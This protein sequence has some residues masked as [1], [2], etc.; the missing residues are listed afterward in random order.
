M[1]SPAATFPPS[2]LP[3]N[4][5][6][7]LITRLG[8]SRRH[9]RR[10]RLP[11]T[12]TKNDST[13]SSFLT[14]LAFTTFSHI[15]QHG[16]ENQTRHSPS[17]IHNNTLLLKTGPAD[18]SPTSTPGNNTMM[19][20]MTNQRT[21][22]NKPEDLRFT[23]L[24]KSDNKFKR[25]EKRM[26]DLFSHHPPTTTTKTTT[27]TTTNNLQLINA[28]KSDHNLESCPSFLQC[29]PQRVCPLSAS[30][31]PSVGCCGGG[32]SFRPVPSTI[33]H[34][35]F[36][37]R[38]KSSIP[39]SRSPEHRWT[40]RRGSAEEILGSSQSS[41]RRRQTG[42]DNNTVKFPTYF[43]SDTHRRLYPHLSSSAGGAA[44]GGGPSERTRG[45]A[46]DNPFLQSIPGIPL[47]SPLLKRPQ[48]QETLPL[49][50]QL[51]SFPFVPKGNFN[52]PLPLK[53]SFSIQLEPSHR[54]S[55]DPFRSITSSP[56]FLS[57]ATTDLTARNQRSAWGGRKD[58]A[59]RTLL[60]SRLSFPRPP[61]PS[62]FPT[63]VGRE[64][65]RRGRNV[66]GRLSFAEEKEECQSPLELLSPPIG[67]TTTG[68]SISSTPNPQR[69]TCQP[70]TTQDLDQLTP[71]ASGG[72]NPP[73]SPLPPN[74]APP[75]FEWHIARRLILDKL[76]PADQFE[77][78]GVKYSHWTLHHV[79]T[80]GATASGGCRCQVMAKV[81]VG[82]GNTG[83]FIKK[84]PAAVWHQQWAE[85]EAWK[86][87]YTTDGEN[88]VGEAAAHSFLSEYYPN[89]VPR[90]V[91]ILMEYSLP[92]G[93]EP[94]STTSSILE[95]A[96]GGDPRQTVQAEAAS[97]PPKSVDY[98]SSLPSPF[99][100][101]EMSPTIPPDWIEGNADDSRIYEAPP[102]K[103][104]TGRKI[105]RVEKYGREKNEANGPVGEETH[106]EKG[107]AA[108]TARE[109]IVVKWVNECQRDKNT[110][111]EAA[112]RD[113]N[114]QVVSATG[115]DERGDVA[116]Y[117]LVSE[118]FGQDLLD[119]LDRVEEQKLK[120]PPDFKRLLQYRILKRLE[121]LHRAGLSHLDF[122][123]ENI[124]IGPKGN[125]KLCD[126]SKSTPLWTSKPLHMS[127]FEN[128]HNSVTPMF[129]QQT[130]TNS[131]LLKNLLQIRQYPYGFHLPNEDKSQLIEHGSEE[132]RNPWKCRQLKILKYTETHELYYP[133]VEDCY[134]LSLAPSTSKLHVDSPTFSQSPS[135]VWSSRSLSSTAS[136]SPPVA[137]SGADLYSFCSCEPTVGKG[138]YMPPEC[139]A[140]VY[141]LQNEGVTEPFK[142]IIGR[143][144]LTN[145]TTNPS[146]V[147]RVN[148]HSVIM[149]IS[150]SASRQSYSRCMD[151]ANWRN[152]ASKTSCRELIRMWGNRLPYYF[153]VELADVYMCGVLMFWIWSEGGV[154]R[155]SDG[156]QDIQYH[157][158]MRTGIDFDIF[159]DCENWSHHL[160]DL[161]KTAL[162]P[163]PCRRGSISELL[164]HPWWSV[165][166]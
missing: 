120:F 149:E 107:T 148:Q 140:L 56:L 92:A 89:T 153:S 53:P 14:D 47:D 63:T 119:F 26:E 134:S 133:R 131:S 88:F 50:R 100:V 74:C 95:D 161:L 97:S 18:S 12:T 164:K 150:D 70:T 165:P 94:P 27:T 118:L 98:Y 15:R 73:S 48:Q 163:D 90:L 67:L 2:P 103:G 79:P 57:Q 39:S 135:T 145:N 93:R 23:A 132:V 160:R 128:P 28:T 25:K 83:L 16:V 91:A 40:I 123:P 66:A 106:Q 96:E 75:L 4:N 157:D 159:K 113:H 21:S 152:D 109:G 17:S 144:E 121:D 38:S 69:F 44:G 115:V 162:Q 8:C 33:T 137:Y 138:P 11:C 64:L 19:T 52:K 116:S 59:M 68:M 117:V 34:H 72:L 142:E 32:G 114:G 1:E 136:E 143:F 51:R 78:N 80:M 99:S 29:F 108:M 129:V 22:P 146:A 71:P 84:V 86:G 13:T 49:L 37:H 141:R 81:R 10:G 110:K 62:S 60:S 61:A 31:P 156:A 101:G 122:T 87:S 9:L 104:S 65:H 3:L 112:R 105:S 127:H 24:Q 5:S 166:L 6:S 45:A 58:P 102:E 111:E 151:L 20:T 82:D 158:L 125:V 41:R 7:P 77:F 155:C 46:H 43:D 30:S 76:V 54:M 42:G 154:W 139:W 126:L 85:E 147:N 130:T 124:L 55:A 35:H 36:F